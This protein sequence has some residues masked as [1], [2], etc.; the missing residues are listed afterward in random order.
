MKQ[1]I[2]HDISNQEYHAG[3]GVS[4]SQLDDIGINPAIYQWRK[5]APVDEQKLS[6]LNMG[7]AL[8]CALLEP[9]EFKN[10]SSSRRNLTGAP[11]Q[12]R[13]PRRHF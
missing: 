9:D 8:H 4:K 11:R 7:T 10:G 2:Y 13:K 5:D 3:P 1:G 6:A 12:E